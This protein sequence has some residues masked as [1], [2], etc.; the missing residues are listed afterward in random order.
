M[1]SKD[2]KVEAKTLPCIFVPF[3]KKH[4][5]SNLLEC[6]EKYKS[7]EKQQWRNASANLA[8][9]RLTELAKYFPELASFLES[10]EK[11]ELGSSS[12]DEIE[13]I[14]VDF[15]VQIS[16]LAIN[17]GVQVSFPVIDFRVQVS[18]MNSTYEILLERISMLENANRQLIVENKALKKKLHE[19]FTNQQDQELLLEKNQ[20]TNMIDDLVNSQ[21]QIGSIKKCT[22]CQASDIN[23]KKQICPNCY[24]KLPMIKLDMQGS[25]PEVHTLQIF[26]SDLIGINPNLIVNIRKVL[27]HIEKVSE[28]KNHRCTLYKK[29]N[30]LK[31]FVELNW[32]I[33]MR[34]FAYYQGYQTENQLQFFKKYSDYHKS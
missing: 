26:I 12:L 29:I 23:N 24:N 17:F 7:K 19:R 11:N 20:K 13:L 4:P 27:E 5:E 28:V 15:G 18:L 33:D 34:D 2:S 10:L 21:S 30:M 3:A 25:V 14:S 6:I 8:T 1:S 22:F 31:A 16:L 9:K 32:D